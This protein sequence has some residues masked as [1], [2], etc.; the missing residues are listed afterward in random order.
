MAH[1]TSG[2]ADHC[3]SRLHLDDLQMAVADLL[4][5]TVVTPP[6][7]DAPFAPEA[8]TPN[9][10]NVSAGQPMPVTDGQTMQGPTGQPGSQTSTMI[11]HL[12]GGPPAPATARHEA[13]SNTHRL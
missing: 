1:F 11:N 9:S 7:M 5:T 10:I 13:S 8:T 6:L 4:N 3:S 2:N 12:T